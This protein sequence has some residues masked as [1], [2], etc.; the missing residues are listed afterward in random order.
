[1]VTSYDDVMFPFVTKI[2]QYPLRCILDLF[3]KN[4][5]TAETRYIHRGAVFF[6]WLLGRW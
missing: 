5:E 2:S 6:T 1:L 4:S 3:E